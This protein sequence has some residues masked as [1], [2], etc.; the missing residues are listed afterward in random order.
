VNASIGGRRI[1]KLGVLLLLSA[2]AL[3]A[4]AAGPERL[5]RVYDED[6]SAAGGLSGP[7]RE[8][9]SGE[10]LRAVNEGALVRLDNGQVLRLDPHTAIV[11]DGGPE[12]EVRV[13]VLSGRVTTVDG[14]GRPLVGGVRSSFTL[15]PI[16]QDEEA[17]ERRLLSLDTER[18][19]RREEEPR[20]SERAERV[21]LSR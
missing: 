17:V 8:L 21:R 11:L 6:A 12:R 3:T 13:R 5:G 18:V 19:S 7:G 16:V 15:A 14:A 4:G 10:L 20:Q 2:L 1:V 9:A